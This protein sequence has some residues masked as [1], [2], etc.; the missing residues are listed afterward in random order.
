MLSMG[1][2]KRYVQTF[3]L[4]FRR[5]EKE[6]ILKLLSLWKVVL[7]LQS[8]NYCTVPSRYLNFY[9]AEQSA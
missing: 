5:Q 1:R 4:A 9:N 6:K 3:M 2:Q 7:P 8:D